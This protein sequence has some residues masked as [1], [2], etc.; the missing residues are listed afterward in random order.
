M[1]GWLLW[2]TFLASHL[3]A[4]AAGLIAMRWLVRRG[5]QAVETA[6]DHV[7][8]H[9][10]EAPMPTAPPPT[11]A[12]QPRHRSLDTVTVRVVVLLVC[13]LVS[14]LVG[15]RVGYQS[16]DE[17]ATCLTDYANELADSQEPRQRAAEVRDQRELEVFAATSRL[18]NARGAGQDDAE[19]LRKALNAY[20]RASR[21]L[22][23]ERAANPYPEAPREVC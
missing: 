2:I 16:F 11:P 12:P 19:A 13:S 10:L 5:A 15:V 8:D 3:G 7:H 9:Q 6:V 4:F 1:P 14:L 17:P 18:L 20:L 21:Q 22:D 23:Q